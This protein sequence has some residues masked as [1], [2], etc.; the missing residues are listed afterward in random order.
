MKIKQ[1]VYNSVLQTLANACCERGGI[2][3][4]KQG[5]VT[6]FYYDEDGK[7]DD[8]CYVPNAS[9]I[10]AVLETWRKED[11]AFAGMVHSHTK[12]APLLSA[13]DRAYAE[14]IFRDNHLKKLYFPLVCRIEDR[15][16]ITAFVFD[17]QWREE[18]VNVIE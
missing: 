8:F 4:C 13:Q 10:N 5:V 3:G 18:Q 15:W 16:Q 2:L 12:G 11:V 1:T 14:S 9:A 7:G 6:H 17:G